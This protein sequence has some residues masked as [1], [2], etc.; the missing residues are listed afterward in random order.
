MGDTPLLQ[1]LDD[2]LKDLQLDRTARGGT[3]IDVNAFSTIPEVR[4]GDFA[5]YLRSV[6]WKSATN[7]ESRTSSQRRDSNSPSSAR[8]YPRTSL[9]DPV[10]CQSFFSL[11]S[12]DLW[13]YY[14]DDDSEVPYA[15]GDLATQ[16]D[17]AEV[18]L[19]EEIR[20][21]NARFMELAALIDDLAGRM[22]DLFVEVS[23]RKEY[24]ANI[25]ADV[26]LFSA[27]SKRLVQRKSHLDDVRK[28]GDELQNVKHSIIVLSEFMHAEHWIGA[29]LV[30]V[31]DLL[32]TLKGFA[33]DSS[34]AGLAITNEV[35]EYV[36]RFSSSLTKWLCRELNEYGRIDC[37]FSAEDLLGFV[38]EQK[39]RHADSLPLEE[40][41]NSFNCCSINNDD[42]DRFVGITTI[43]RSMNRLGCLKSGFQEFQS[44]IHDQAYNFLL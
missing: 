28:I 29:N 4:I 44:D 13:K 39:I 7:D 15:C 36:N 16:L 9:I 22:S 8:D 18:L 41:N 43:L 19:L 20:K 27:D 17:M 26:Q 11:D 38:S 32:D 42:S 1:D 37:R 31:L 12:A 10:F 24:F 21:Q 14:D 30:D 3:D 25:D 40:L 34:L 23:T 33:M 5:R 6:K 35:S 2:Y